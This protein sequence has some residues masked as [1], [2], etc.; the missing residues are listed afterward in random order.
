VTTN[1]RDDLK[2]SLEDALRELG[3]TADE[4]GAPAPASNS[5]PKTNELLQTVDKHV[6]DLLSAVDPDKDADELM[7]TVD[8]MFTTDLGEQ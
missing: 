6:D 3:Q 8:Q 4:L 7:N 1:V 2:E 5:D